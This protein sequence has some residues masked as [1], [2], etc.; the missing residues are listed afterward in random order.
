MTDHLLDLISVDDI[1]AARRRLSGLIRETPLR[2]VQL[3]H[4]PTTDVLVKCE[5][6]QP[7][8]SFKLRGAL[9]ALLV[10]LERG[11]RRGFI[12][13]SA[14]NHGRALAHAAQIAGVPST[15]VMP[16]T[17]TEAKVEWTRLAGAE[18]VVV[19]PDDIVTRAHAI[20]DERG[21]GFIHPFD[22][23]DVIAGQGTVALEILD[24]LGGGEIDAILVPVGGGGLLAG[25]ARILSDRLPDTRIIGVEPEF[26]G[27]LAEG[28]RTGTRVAW[29]REQTR[30]TI[31]DGLRSPQVGALPWAHISALVDD[32]LTVPEEGILDALR[33]LAVQTDTVIEP[34][35]AVATAALLHHG[36]TFRGA[37]VVS[38]LTGGNVDDASF[39]KLLGS[40]APTQSTPTSSRPEE[41]RS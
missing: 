15:V 35:A 26:A 10:A 5:N 1:V 32:V 33:L 2:A 40:P 28:F 31:A 22:D 4:D 13:Y 14:G 20:E 23:R 38:L 8:G 34:S 29:G 18:V 21:L 19:D 9:N 24:Q 36:D 12:T 41:G 11:P 37:R 7:T 27:D 39:A 17:A 25:I 16:A 6:L 30:R 3:P